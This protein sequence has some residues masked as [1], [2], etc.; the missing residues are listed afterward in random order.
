[1]IAS[2]V[3]TALTAMT[4]VAMCRVFA[5]WQF[6]PTLLVMAL[7]V[8][9]TS[10]LLRIFRVPSAVALVVIVLVGFELMAVL[11][12]RDTLQFGIPSSDTLQL[13]R[14][15]LR[16]V[17][18]QFPS[19][20]APVPSSGG[21]LVAAAYGIGI[22]AMF[23]DAFAFR[24]YGRAEAVV[25]AGVLFVFTAALGTDRN[26]IAVATA[27]FAT[28]LAVVAVLRAL[29]GG[30][31]ESWLGRRRRAV[32]AALPATAMCAAVAAL[33]AAMIGPILPGAGSEPLLETRQS[34]SDVTTV[35]SPLVDIR[36]RLVN[37]TNTEMFTVSSSVGRYWR[38]TGLTEFDGQQWG[39]PDRV[40]GDAEGELNPVSPDAQVVQQQITI[41]RFGGTLVPAAFTPLTVSQRNLG[42]LEDT[43]TIVVDGDGLRQGQVFNVA[44]DIT[45][46]SVGALRA[47][48]TDAPP[49]DGLLAL[50]D[51]LPAEVRTLAAEVTAGA[52]T[53]YDRARAIQDWFRINFT[54]DLTVQ[55]GHSDD[56]ITS[57]L[58]IR[59]GYCEQFAG[60]FAVMARSVGLPA[61][62]AVGFTQG[63]LRS[64][65]KYHVLGRHAHA[66][67]EVWFDGIGWVAFEPT[68]GR[69]APGNEE[70]TGAPVAQDDR[71]GSTGDGTGIPAPTTTTPNVTATT[72]RDPLGSGGATTTTLPPRATGVSGDG[73]AGTGPFGWI[74]LA[75]GAVGLW[76]WVMPGLVRRFTRVGATPS[77][78]VI[79]AWHGTVGSLQLAGA[80]SPAGCTPLEY[81]RTIEQEMAVDVRSLTELARFVTRAVYAPEGVGE[82]AALRAA[83]LRTHLDEAARGIMPWHARL[84]ARIDPRLVRQRLV[85]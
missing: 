31:T 13:M 50:P 85:G 26:R 55:S 61:R 21:F 70:V 51:D 72:E 9:A 23:S 46:P 18:A 65:G 14:L 47:A 66:W 82:P 57:F 64:D 19:A 74:L 56:A 71:T 32:G 42:W 45:V 29:H 78:Q 10:V 49:S 33:G 67:P 63:E 40:L 68:P 39:L 36:S 43:D 35:L 48:T 17:W 34:Q 20:V 27:W 81:A 44:S 25:P 73:D 80:P 58:R 4:A 30:G 41:S 16:L 54:Y 79:S 24:A 5:D 2:V 1:M 37:R 6:L 69:G 7:G 8:H 84:W 38:I 15:D 12:Y 75:F 3:V 52:E 22:V 53:P 60:T 59:R 77:E 83:V 76:A 11:F 62:V 28:A